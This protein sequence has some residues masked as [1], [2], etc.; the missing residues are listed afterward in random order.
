[1]ELRGRICRKVGEDYITRSFITC[2]LHQ[3]LLGSSNQ[4]GWDGRGL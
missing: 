2:N 1:L 3:T 4:G